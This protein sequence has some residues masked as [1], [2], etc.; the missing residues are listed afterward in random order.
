MSYKAEFCS[1]L[2]F[3]YL[4]VLF[5]YFFFSDKFQFTKLYFDSFLVLF[6]ERFRYWASNKDHFCCFVLSLSAHT[7]W[8]G[9][10]TGAVGVPPAKRCRG[11]VV[12]AVWAGRPPNRVCAACTPL[13]SGV[14]AGT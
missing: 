2:F 9:S 13:G 7:F 3:L 8:Q 6:N 10:W 11:C 4:C 1:L 5:L 14:D 12:L